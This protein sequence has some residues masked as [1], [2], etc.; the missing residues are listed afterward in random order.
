MLMEVIWRTI[1]DGECKSM[2]LLWILIWGRKRE[3]IR[4]MLDELNEE[5]SNHKET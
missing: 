2:I 3:L 1:S 5:M 4:E